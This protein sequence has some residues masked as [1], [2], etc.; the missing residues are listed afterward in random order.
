[1]II[2]CTTEHAGNLSA[3]YL[4]PRAG[5]DRRTVFPIRKHQEYVVTPFRIH[6]GEHMT[7]RQRFTRLWLAWRR[8]NPPVSRF[9][10]GQ[11][12]AATYDLESALD[13]VVS[14]VYALGSGYLG[15]EEW[16]YGDLAAHR[17]RELEEVASMLPGTP[18]SAALRSELAIYIDATRSLLHV[19]AA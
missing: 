9:R 2:R 16:D 11:R 5:L 13:H 1:M 18:M 6:V 3:A 19:L 17:L 8:Q 10:N 14:S 12:S 15:G 4:E 7:D